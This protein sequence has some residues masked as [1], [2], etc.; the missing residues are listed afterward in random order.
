VLNEI[1][2]STKKR[3]KYVYVTLFEF[4]PYFENRIFFRKYLYNT[5]NNLFGGGSN[6]CK[7][8]IK[9]NKKINKFFE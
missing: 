6:L 7:V 1:I 8:K 9:C 3:R 5:R 4:F 2:E